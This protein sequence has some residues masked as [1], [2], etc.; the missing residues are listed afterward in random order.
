MNAKAVCLMLAG[1]M[2]V[3]GCAAPAPPSST[4]APA[5]RAP[6]PLDSPILKSP[7]QPAQPPADRSAGTQPL[8][9]SFMETQLQFAFDVLNQS[10]DSN[11]GK[12]VFVS[13]PNV[14]LA[15]AIAANGAQG[16]TF[17]ALAAPLAGKGATRDQ[18]NTDFAALQAQLKQ[19]SGSITLTLANSLWLNA[20][21]PLNPDYL[22]RTQQYYDATLRVLDFAQPQSADEINQWVQGATNGKIP[23]IV[24]QLTADQALL[25][26]SAIYFKA[27]WLRPFRA[28]LTED[29]PFS[30][31]SGAQVTVPMMSQSGFFSHLKND[32]FE[33][34][35]LPYAGN[36]ARMVV[37]LPAEGSDVDALRRQLTP[38][39]WAAWSA[40]FTP[41]QGTLRLPRFKTEFAI[42]LNDALENMGMGMAFDPQR[43]DFA[44][45]RPAP[46]NL[47]ISEVKHRSV[48]DV[49]E[50]G[51][52]AAA[53]TSVSMGTTSARP[54]AKPF[55]MTVDRPFLFAIEDRQSGL[56]LFEGIIHQ[57]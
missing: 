19:N 49:D 50:A 4:P 47:F 21:P 44:G 6:A 37:M 40:T 10:A 23:A 28:E 13:A 41:A 9:A 16:E 30:L 35:Y 45:M 31:A 53:V 51:T 38:Q 22:Q 3:A 24:D 43:A 25:I 8:P 12:N 39:N 48:I 29:Q 36:T 34:I 55:E 2:A 57:P 17:D 11:A 5:T 32:Q 54:S 52:E 1:V 7:L 15:L 20:G 18:M 14:A 56:L 26:V 27:A 33:A 42:T 46:P